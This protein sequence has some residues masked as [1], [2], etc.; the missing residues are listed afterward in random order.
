MA[1]VSNLSA[2]RDLIGGPTVRWLY[3]G[4]MVLSVALVWVSAIAQTPRGERL[5][6]PWWPMF[7]SLIGF[8]VPGLNVLGLVTTE[9]QRTLA[10]LLAVVVTALLP[11]AERLAQRMSA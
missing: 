7:A 9:S 8:A 2:L 3:G 6:H 1:C 11:I 4:G 10:A 5:P